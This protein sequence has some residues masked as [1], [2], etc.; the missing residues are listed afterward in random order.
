M[1]RKK[2]AL[3]LIVL[4][5]C[6]GLAAC[7]DN[8][9]YG[10]I[11]HISSSE[12]TVQTGSYQKPVSPDQESGTVSENQENEN[13]GGASGSKKGNHPAESSAEA[14]GGF[15]P[16]GDAAAY[17]LSEDVDTGNLTEGELVKLTFTGKLVSSIETLQEKSILGTSPKK[18]DVSP[19][20]AYTIRHQE[21]TLVNQDFDSSEPDI[22]AVLV[23]DQ[24]TLE[25]REG[26]LT[27]SGNT[28]SQANSSAYGL[29][30]I[31]LAC[32]G[33]SVS[34][35]NTTFHSSAAGSNAVFAA[36]KGTKIRLAK[37][38]IN[39]TESLSCGLHA[40]CGGTIVASNGK[41]TTKGAKCAPVYASGEDNVIKVRNTTLRASGK[42]SPCI[43]S[44]GTVTCTNTSGSAASSQIAIV[45]GDS[46]ITLKDCILQGAGNHG[47]LL[48]QSSTEQTATEEAVLKA[49]D[50]K[51]TT[52]SKGP[53]F[54][55]TNTKASSVLENSSLYFS[56][57]ILAKVSGKGTDSA[58][59]SEKSGG[60]FTL[61]GIGQVFKGDIICDAA[62]SVSLVLTDRSSLKGAVNHSGKA[63]SASVSLDQSSF[64]SVSADSYVTELM[65]QKASCSNI[66]SNG[67]TI[68]YDAGNSS[69]K[70]L[71]GKTVALPGGG[72][73]TPVRA[74]S[75]KESAET[76]AAS[77]EKTDSSISPDLSADKVDTDAGDTLQTDVEQDSKP[78][79]FKKP[80]SGYKENRGTNLTLH[81]TGQALKG[82]VT[83]TSAD[84]VSL[85]LTKRTTL[86]GAVNPNRKAK[87]VSVFL[88]KSSTWNVT[89]DS[90][91][92]ELTNLDAS[93][94]NILSNGYTIYYDKSCDSNR[95]L[96]GK[97]ISLPGGGILTPL[98]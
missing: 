30:S 96:S 12:I 71:G 46:K 17:T 24:G 59:S 91:V 58:K 68:Y 11:T 49:A 6:T 33:S 90:Y 62:S 10:K 22:S 21:K 1:F 65:N 51:L 78:A 87:S 84:T 20:A 38:K 43:Y 48:R 16:D 29:N 81:G 35:K 18:G 67:N 27:K 69:N 76:S 37:F 9:I 74:S 86:T 66:L 26:R 55:I 15:T 19:S 92:T 75:G 83:C 14:N 63:K 40:V 79:S 89:G 56:S 4:A 82:D 80:G 97:T 23:A 7:S 41:I 64:W 77:G 70:W 57:G 52:T 13:Q 45:E 44:A 34:I 88:D 42:G 53:M 98:K 93:C 32:G 5:A 3:L 85:S 61:K 72:K 8:V 60:D 25:L 31:L 94:R 50:S 54:Y 39:T 95:W 47:I 2:A 73:L 28:T 36:G